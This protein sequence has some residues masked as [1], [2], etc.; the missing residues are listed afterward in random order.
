[1]RFT[2]QQEQILFP[3][4]ATVRDPHGDRY[5]VEGLLGRGASGAVYLVSDK[6]V[7]QNVFALKEV[8]NPNKRDRDRFTFEGEIL[9]RLHHRALPRVYHSFEHDNLKRVYIL[10]DYIKGRNLEDLRE[11]QPEKCFSLPLVLALVSP[12]VDALIYLHSQD[13]PIIH[14]DI[15]PANIVVPIGADEAMLVDFGSAK[16]YAPDGLTTVLSHRSPGYAA[17]EQ[18][19]GGTNTRTDI[20]GLG[21]TLYLLLTGTVPTDALSRV[22]RGRST[23]ADPLKPANLLRREVPAAVAEALQRAMSLSSADRFETVEEFWQVLQAHT[24]D[25]QVEIPRV[26]SV[27]AYQ[28]LPLRA[29]QRTMGAFYLKGQDIL[30]S[31]KRK[32][33]VFVY[34]TL[35]VTFVLGTALLSHL[36]GPTALLLLVVLLVILALIPLLR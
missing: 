25:K 32:R 12:I 29:S 9:K 7:K 14:R 33:V 10:M 34:A 23:G 11:E 31:G 30:R 21:A 8:I 28:P 27:V 22:V 20:Y 2:M 1:M 4:G 3:K 16:E 5:V 6:R 18:Y 19:V 24:T 35:L 26:T 13:P 15:K 36:F 17:P